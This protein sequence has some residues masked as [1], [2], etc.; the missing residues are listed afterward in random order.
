MFSDRINAL[1]S[2]VDTGLL[3]FSTMLW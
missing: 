2:W 3:D 1:V